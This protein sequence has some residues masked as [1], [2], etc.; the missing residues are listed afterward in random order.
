MTSLKRLRQIS[1]DLNIEPYQLN[2]AQ[3]KE[4]SKITEWDLRKCGGF[5]TILKTY[6]P[7]EKDLKEIQLLKARKAY[8]EKL[9]K[10]YGSWEL[11]ADNLTSS[12]VKTL[13]KVKVEPVIVDAKTT[14]EYIKGMLQKNCMMALQGP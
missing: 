9:E 7:Y 5:E 4:A 3:F 1:K 14:Q 8:V 11:F 13:K 6:F 10:Q 2:K 12:L